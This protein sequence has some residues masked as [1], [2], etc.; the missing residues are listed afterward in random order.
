[1][2][3]TTPEPPQ[4]RARP[5][6]VIEIGTNTSKLLVADVSASTGAVSPRM[7][8]KEATRIGEGLSS[9]GEVAAAAVLRT[10]NAIGRFLQLARQYNCEHV[11]GFST[12][13]LRVATN[14]AE[15]AGRLE[16][17]T[18]LGF[19]IITGEEE[20]RF[21]WISARANLGPGAPNMYIIDLGGGSTEFVHANRSGIVETL[22]LPLGA[23]QLTEQF[24]HADPVAP[25]EMNRLRKYVSGEVASV[26]ARGKRSGLRPPQVDLI[27]SGGSVTT[28][29]K[30]SDLS[31]D[32]S[33]LTSP[34][35]RIGAVRRLE[36]KCLELPLEKRKRLPGL[37]P[38]R[39][40]IIPAGLAVLLAFLE[41]TGKRVL[42]VNP[43]GV[44]LGVLL[45]L[46]RNNYLW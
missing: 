40:D 43:D 42:T 18:G 3:G 13:A 23:L 9:T 31:W 17:E 21:A 1:M 41:A 27:A 35:I 29:R 46:F 15:V 12:H 45:H 7:F 5:V 11:A 20:A 33:S 44:R 38:D 26:F 37:D 8:R 16:D 24:L 19:R 36:A 39:A 32:F 6:A 25:E 30:M 14:G 2:N 22:S 28:I 34:K 4:P 10:V